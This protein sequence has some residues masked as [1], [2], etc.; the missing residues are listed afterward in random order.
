MLMLQRRLLEAQLISDS[1]LSSKLGLFG[2]SP[3]DGGA[4]SRGGTVEGG[5]KRTR[6][7]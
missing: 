2:G 7:P 1:D 5:Y 3:G 6:K 4:Q